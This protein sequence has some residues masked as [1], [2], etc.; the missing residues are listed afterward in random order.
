MEIGRF[1]NERAA[2][3]LVDYLKG[4]GIPCRITHLEQGV[5]IHVIEDTDQAKGRKAFLDFV[6]DP[7]NPKYLQASWDH[8]DN[9]IRFD[10]GAPS[11]QL[12]SQFITGAGP[13]T[14]I[15]LLVCIAIFAAMNLG[16]GNQV[17]EA[18]AFFGATSDAGFSQFWRLFTPSL[19][20]FSALHITFNLLWW[21]VLGGKIENRIGLAPLLTLL[22]VA[23]TLPNIVQF[24]LSGPNFGGLSGVVYG[25][26]GYT[27]VSGRMSPEKGIGLPPALMGFMLLWLVLGFMDVFGLSIANGAH[28]SGLLV[29][30]AQGWLD[31]RGKK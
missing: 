12:L 30:L 1:P 23:G 26:V 29:G 14:L 13:L 10:Y 7:L 9:R 8:G 6:Q 16:Y 28:L 24:Y 20:H 4:E 11:L 17:F 2:Q 3:A 18:L 27:W 25:L 5:A 31:N 15:I 22:L 21:W 19:L